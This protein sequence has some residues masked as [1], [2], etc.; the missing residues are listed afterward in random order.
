MLFDIPPDSEHSFFTDNPGEGIMD[1]IAFH[2]DS[3][4]GPEDENHPMINRTI[5]DG[6]SAS[7][8]KNITTKE[9][10]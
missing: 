4:Y 1:V 6:K 2:P 3:D 7:G 10:K 8:N 5:I 9:I